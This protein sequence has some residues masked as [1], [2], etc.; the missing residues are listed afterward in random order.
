MYYNRELNDS[1]FGCLILE[2]FY[3]NEHTFPEGYTL[4]DFHERLMNWIT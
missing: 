1:L 4:G 3:T 2:Y